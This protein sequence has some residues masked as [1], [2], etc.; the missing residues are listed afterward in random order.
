MYAHQR[1]HVPLISSTPRCAGEGKT[2]F[3]VNV[4]PH[5]CNSAGSINLN[6]C[7]SVVSSSVPV[8]NFKFVFDVSTTE[9]VYHLAAD[10]E[11]ERSEWVS[12][13][14]ELLFPSSKVRACVKYVFACH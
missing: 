3:G 9:R 13:L 2:S 14:K 8:K 5:Y 7:L 11:K 1:L 4:C 12:T 10:S 6:T